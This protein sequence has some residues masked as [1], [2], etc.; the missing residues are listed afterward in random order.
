MSAVDTT[1]HDNML[2]GVDPGDDDNRD[3]V[4][5]RNDD[6]VYCHYW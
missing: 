1:V 4:D 6:L 2:L 3:D 5:D